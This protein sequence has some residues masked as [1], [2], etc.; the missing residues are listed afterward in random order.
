MRVI[1]FNVIFFVALL[2]NCRDSPSVSPPGST[3][4]D[5]KVAV[6][7]ELAIRSGPGLQYDIVTHV[8]VHANILA[9]RPDEHKCCDNILGI[10]GSWIE[11]EYAGKKG[12]A[13]KPLLRRVSEQNKQCRLLHIQNKE[14]RRSPCKEKP[15]LKCLKF[16]PEKFPASF[17][18]GCFEWSSE[19]SEEV[20][21][22]SKIPRTI[23]SCVADG[24]INL[25]S[26]GRAIQTYQT[27]SGW[28]GTWSGK[29][30]HLEIEL[31]YSYMDCD[32]AC[33]YDYQEGEAE[34]KKCIRKCEAAH[35]PLPEHESYRK[36]RLS[37]NQKGSVTLQ[38]WNRSYEVCIYP[39][40][41]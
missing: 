12:W 20:V 13:F 9:P 31:F 25:Y 41:D 29:D 35:I 5:F 14:L 38:D 30:S 22:N 33:L 23:V 8:P 37:L 17:K 26:D 11:I 32:E 15:P 34:L 28:D 36:L 10:K 24:L 19:P 4:F 2:S 1:L 16:R 3:N 6:S 39:L 21:H 27:H 18:G 7:P 40:K